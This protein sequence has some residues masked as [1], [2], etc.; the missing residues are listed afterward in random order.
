MG[1]SSSSNF[2]NY[3]SYKYNGKEIQETGMYDYGARMYMSDIGRW[4]VINPLAEQMRRFS[5]YNYA[6]NNPIRFI[7]PDG[8]S[9]RDTY[10]EHSAFNGDFNPNSSLSGY[11]GMGGSHG[12]YFASNT[13]GGGGSAWGYD[14]KTFGE[15]QAYRD[16]MTSLQN[17]GDFSLKT[18]NG[19]MSWWTGGATGD[20]TTSQEMIAH[21]LKLSGSYIDNIDWHKTSQGLRTWSGYAFSANKFVF[22]PAADRAA[23]YGAG[24]AFSTTNLV[25]EKTLPKILGSPKIYLPIMEISAVGAQRLAVGTRVAGT[26]LGIA[27]IALAGYDIK[28]N[29][30]TTSNSLDLVMSV[31]AVSPTGWG[32]AIAGT[33]FLANGI[34]TLVT[35]K[36]IGQHI[37]GA[38]NTYYNN[39]V[40]AEEQRKYNA[41]MGY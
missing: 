23:L 9:P 12:N 34:T 32:Q 30:V 14:T 6:F 20:A 13:G 5:P 1:G 33:Y 18:H 35:G 24:K 8:N 41:A 22:Q 11:N 31:L 15:T 4:G 2:G 29:G 10:G 25:F 39:G 21:V 37:E 38:A 19:Y 40:R 26:A 28:N 27:G 17:G 3:Y 16:L 7:D 36:D